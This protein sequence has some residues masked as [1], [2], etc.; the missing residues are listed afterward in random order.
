MGKK[1]ERAPQEIMITQGDCE[2]H[3]AT[4]NSSLFEVASRLAVGCHPNGA[5]P[6]EMV[7]TYTMVYELLQ[8]WYKGTPLKEEVKKMLHKLLPSP[9]GYESDGDPA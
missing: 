1:N 8:A 3:Q 6:Q 4:I 2:Q 9:P 7:A 5:N